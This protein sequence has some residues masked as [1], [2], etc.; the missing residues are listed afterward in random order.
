MVDVWAR[1]GDFGARCVGFVVLFGGCRVRFGAFEWPL[2]AQWLDP[3]TP[4]RPR[5]GASSVPVAQ[6]W[7]PKALCRQPK[8]DGQGPN[9]IGH[10]LS[11]KYTK[12]S[13]KPCFFMVRQCSGA[14][15]EDLFGDFSLLG[16]LWSTS[17]RALATLGRS[18]SALG[19]S[20]A[21]LGDHLALKASTRDPFHPAAGHR[22]ASGN[23]ILD[24]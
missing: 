23:S 3:G 17:G 14:C 16:A 24:P 8:V 22:L 7:T 5:A 1:F 11:A 21:A 12:T 6:F 13:G 10:G 2:G 4:S 9:A 20:L 19:S 15:F 18:V